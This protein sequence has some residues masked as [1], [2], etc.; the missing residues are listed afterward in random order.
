MAERVFNLPDLGE[1]LEDA[2]IVEWK[3]SEGDTVELNQ[4]LVDVNTA[5]ALVEIPSPF[6][7]KV[8]KLHGT[9]GDVVKVGDPLITIDVEGAEAS[10]EAPAPAPSEAAIA[11]APK[12]EAVLVG[13]GVNPEETA[14]RQRP[15]LRPPGERK[16]PAATTAPTPS[17][18]R[19]AAAPPVRR[20]AKEIGVDLT[21]VEGTGPS[22][23]VTREDVIQAAGSER[24]TAAGAEPS[25]GMPR[26]AGPEERV[27]VRGVRR[28]IAQKMARSW[29]EIPHVTTFHLVDATHVEALRRELTEQ[30]GVKVTALSVV[31]SA[32]VKAWQAHPKLNASYDTEAGELV[33]K[34]AYHVGI[35]T[36]TD[37]GLMV[38]VVRDAGAKGIVSLAGE[39][40]ELVGAA[41]ERRATP[42]QLTGGTIT[43]TNVGTFGS[44]FGTPI[45]NFPEVAILAIGTIKP[46]A[47]VVDGEIRVTPAVTLS[48]SFDHRVIDGAEAD[49][50]MTAL[51]E[52]LESPFRLGAL[53]R[54]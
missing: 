33:L 1:G 10:P 5:K 30:S 31:V 49:R 28:M 13:Y 48:L 46:R 12:R 11:E 14:K 22:G 47:L 37:Q 2:E 29:A 44:E 6:A 15:R 50:A 20:L 53:P 35:A 34:R 38:P 8:V 7:G 41:R 4:P 3:V 17:A 36:D 21:S 16:A 25:V 39:I 54:E 32:L 52:L 42:E 18:G 51:R 43:V 24:P 9:D 40:A 26:F 23:R 27:P 45:I 19:V